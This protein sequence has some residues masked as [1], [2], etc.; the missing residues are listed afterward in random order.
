MTSG[1]TRR[2]SK[3]RPSKAVRGEG[4]STDGVGKV[5][6]LSDREHKLELMTPLRK[7]G[8]WKLARPV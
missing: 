3:T 8:C 7:A 4:W 5:T 2:S 1:Q 6:H